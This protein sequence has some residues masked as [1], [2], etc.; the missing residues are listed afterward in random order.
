[1]VTNGTDRTNDLIQHPAGPGLAAGTSLTY[2]DDRRKVMVVHGRNTTARNA[3]FAF[4]RSIDLHPLD[5]T[6][7]VGSATAGAPYIGDVLDGA[8]GQA[9]AVVVLSNAR[10]CRVSQSRARTRR[11]SRARGSSAR[12]SAS[13][14]FS[15]GRDVTRSI[16]HKDDPGRVGRSPVGERPAGDD[17]QVHER[18]WVTVL[19]GEVEITSR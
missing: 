10:R 16:P 18:V 17:H 11:R 15:R 3:M 5:W 8:F 6:E 1:M 7:L 13:E 9:Q 12:S 4:L 2:A 19:D 14:C